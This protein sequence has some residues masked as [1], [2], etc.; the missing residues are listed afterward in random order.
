[1]RLAGLLVVGEGLAGAALAIRSMTRP[2]NGSSALELVVAA[3]APAL[4]AIAAGAALYRG[5]WWPRT[6]VTITQILLAPLAV[7][8]TFSTPLG[9]LPLITVALILIGLYSP[10]SNRWMNH[11]YDLTPPPAPMPFRLGGN[12]IE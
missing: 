5:R 4:L 3:T 11:A 12:Q 2:P 6:P 1:M 10:P 8:N 9:L 7:A